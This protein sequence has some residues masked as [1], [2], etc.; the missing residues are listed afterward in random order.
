VIAGDQLV[1]DGGELGHIGLVA[2]VGAGDHR[3]PAI[4]G[5]Y[6]GQ[7]DQAQVVAFLLGLATLGD[8]RLLVP[9][10]DEGGEVGHVTHQGCQIQPELP[11]HRH[12]E[13]AFDLGQLR[14]RQRVHG[15]PE[16]AVIQR[17]SWDLDPP[18]RGRGGPPVRERQLRARAHNPV[19]RGQRQVGAHRGSRV[20][21][22]R[23]GH[24]IDDL[25][26]PQPLDHRPGRCYIPECQVLCALREHRRAV[27]GRGDVGGLAQVPLRDDLRPATDPGDFP[28]VVVRLA[29][30][31]L[32]DQA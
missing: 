4:A 22:S 13:P 3:D 2:R 26:H 24:L 31:P 8:R 17:R 10:V 5:D 16:P 19:Q 29:A 14:R 11:G 15:V 25:G 28:Q 1:D 20:R 23:S 32:T 21:P 27:H 30:D 12:A 9:G 7:P 6:Q 18:V